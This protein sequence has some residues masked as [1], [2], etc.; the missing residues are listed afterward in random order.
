MSVKGFGFDVV[1]VVHSVFFACV[2]RTEQLVRLPL[3]KSRT[4]SI[5]GCPSPSL[6]HTILVENTQPVV[7]PACV[8]VCVCVQCNMGEVLACMRLNDAFR[9]ILSAVAIGIEE[10]G[11]AQQ[12]E[13]AKEV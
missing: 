5:L 4:R 8:H 7:T 11:F 3:T 12:A 6:A 13:E 10:I 9:L 2:I 1:V